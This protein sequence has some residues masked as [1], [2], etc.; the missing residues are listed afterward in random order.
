MY[1]FYYVNPAYKG[2]KHVAI[3]CNKATITSDHAGFGNKGFTVSQIY[4]TN[5]KTFS[6]R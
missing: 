4:E 5:Y 1:Y 3:S 2:S 6:L